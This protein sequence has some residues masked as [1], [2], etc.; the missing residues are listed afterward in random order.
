MV[1]LRPGFANGF[2]MLGLA[3]EEVGNVEEAEVS[4]RKAIELT[5]R[6]KLPRN[7][8]A[9]ES[10]EVSNHEKPFC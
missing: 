2:D 10:R 7:L 6:Q 3:L 8:S 9:L 4:Y 1:K 5:E